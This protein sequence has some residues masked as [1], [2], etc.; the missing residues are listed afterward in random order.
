MPNRLVNC[1]LRSDIDQNLTL[2]E[3]NGIVAIATSAKVDPS[4]MGTTARIIELKAGMSTPISIKTNPQAVLL[5]LNQPVKV[6][7]V[8]ED[9]NTGDK[10]VD[11]DPGTRWA[12]AHEDNQWIYVDLGATKKIDK[13]SINWESAGAKDF[14]IQVSD[15]AE[16][17]TTVKSVDNN[18]QVGI[19]IYPDLDTQGRSVRINC[20]T[21]LTGY[22]F[23]IRELGVYGSDL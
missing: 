19:L 7:S 14:D 15:D 22:G 2:I 16:S 9:E 23:S 6:S 18:N 20:K 10:A 12:S 5:S 1:T 8:G 11:G 21:R 13:V 17:W 3:R 4:P